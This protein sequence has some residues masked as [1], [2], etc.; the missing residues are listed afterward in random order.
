M[1]LQHIAAAVAL[2]AAGTANAAIATGGNGSLVMIAYDKLGGTTTAGVFDLGL[3]MDDL[4]GATGNGTGVAATSLAGLNSALQFNFNTNTITVNGVTTSAY[5]NNS[6]TA[7]WNTLLA[8]SDAADLQFV[9]TAFD[10][11]GFGANLRSIVTGTA[12]NTN[13]FLSSQATGLQAIAGGKANDIFTPLQST[14]T[15]YKGTITADAANNGAYTFTAAD[16]ATTRANGYAMAGDAFGNEWRSNNVLNGETLASNTASLYVVDGNKAKF[17]M[18][19][20]VS[21]SAANGTLTISAVPEPT[22]YALLVSGLAV[23]GAVAR[24]RRA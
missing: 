9:V 15:G 22:T 12:H 13:S 24:R 2:V 16:G 8:N 21:L 23:V 7:A 6:W 19:Y 5:G 17:E 10:T 18:Q 1:K 3:T 14:I 4:I 11:V 20:V